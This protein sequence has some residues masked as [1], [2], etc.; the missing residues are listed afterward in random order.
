M[1]NSQWF[2]LA[3][4]SLVAVS[5]MAPLPSDAYVRFNGAANQADAARDMAQ[6]DAGLYLYV[7]G[8]DQAVVGNNQM[9]VKCYAY[10]T[11][12][13]V[14]SKSYNATPLS[15]DQGIA[16]D[17]DSNGDVWAT[18]TTN[19]G[20]G[21]SDIV[22]VKFDGYPFI[23]PAL[24]GQILAVHK[25]G[26]TAKLNDAPV[27]IGC[28]DFDA[29]KPGDEVYIAANA[30]NTGTNEDIV[31]ICLDNNGAPSWISQY[32]YGFGL[33]DHANCLVGPRQCT[34]GYGA[35]APSLATPTVAI[36]GKVQWKDGDYDMLVKGFD[37][38]TGSMSTALIYD[39]WVHAGDANGDDWIMDGDADNTGIYFTGSTKTLHEAYEVGT[40]AF[41]AGFIGTINY[42]EDH[43][44]ASVEAMLDDYGVDIECDN[45]NQVFVGAIVPQTNAASIPTDIGI[46]T[47]DVNLAA[48]VW[49][50]F[51][52]VNTLDEVVSMSFA[53]GNLVVSAGC[54][55]GAPGSAN[56][57]LISRTGAGAFNWG[58][59]YNPYGRYD[60]PA[61]VRAARAQNHIYVV[62]TS[63]SGAAATTKDWFS[64]KHLL[65]APG[66]IIW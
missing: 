48:L 54:W 9:T 62:G 34:D 1:K 25:F 57:V 12:A 61:K 60:W 16:I 44:F 53:N 32:D 2:N 13:L 22:T 49:T 43:R 10:S 19:N 31:V 47:P 27:D 33:N 7:V 63:A 52:N 42:R 29:M 39:R 56:A 8:T 18:G 4:L 38:V 6:D 35:R 30:F 50:N 37:P 3:L 21:S 59:A 51:Q 64:A 14:W 23:D 41:H 17:V 46:F 40:V 28:A 20:A 5:M 15:N 36:G 55:N 66:T 65:I 26:G 24:P 58:Y 45:W 11:G